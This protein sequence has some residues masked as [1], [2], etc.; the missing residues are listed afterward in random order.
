[1]AVAA[2]QDVF[3]RVLLFINREAQGKADGA[4]LLTQKHKDKNLAELL[5]YWPPIYTLESRKTVL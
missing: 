4:Y 3:E 2:W 1:M 5:Y